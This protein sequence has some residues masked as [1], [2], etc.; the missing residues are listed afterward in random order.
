M[1]KDWKQQEG[2]LRRK[3][4]AAIEPLKKEL[5][6]YKLTEE[7]DS[8]IQA[9]IQESTDKLVSTPTALLDERK[10]VETYGDGK[11]TLRPG[12]NLTEEIIQ[13][14][15]GGEADRTKLRLTVR[16]A[17]QKLKSELFT[18]VSN[19][20]SPIDVIRA[21][22]LGA[23]IDLAAKK[24]GLDKIE[25]QRIRELVVRLSYPPEG[26][27]TAKMELIAEETMVANN[28]PSGKRVEI[29]QANAIYN[30]VHAGKI[31]RTVTEINRISGVLGGSEKLGQLGT[32]AKF[33]K[34]HPTMMR[35]LE[36]IQGL[37]KFQDS[38]AGFIN[39]PVGF[40]LKTEAFKN[41]SVQ[42]ATRLGGQA[43][44]N[45]VAQAGEFT[46]GGA[47]RNFIG[48]LFVKTA[49][50]AAAN[51]AADAV[52][53]GAEASN[54]LGWALAL[55]QVGLSLIKPFLEKIGK[56]LENNLSIGSAK[57][58][59]AM[60]DTFGNIFGTIGYYA[61]EALT[62][63]LGITLGGTAAGFGIIAAVT[64]G[65]LFFFHSSNQR[66]TQLFVAPKGMGADAGCVETDSSGKGTPGT[67]SMN[68]DGTVYTYVDGNGNTWQCSSIPNNTVGGGTPIPGS[69]GLPGETFPGAECDVSSAVVP[70]KQCDGTWANTSLI[71]ARCSGGGPGTICS[72]G[73]GP[74]S[75]SMLLR[76]INGGLTPPGTI[77]EAG[78]PYSSMG[79]DGSSLQQAITSLSNHGL[80]AQMAAGSSCSPKDIAGWICQHKVVLVL[81]NF[82][83][84][85]SDLTSFG[86][87]FILAVAVKGGK[88]YS[89]DPYYNTAT[90]FDGTT[91]FGYVHD[92]MG[93]VN[94]GRKVEKYVKK[95]KNINR[96]SNRG[97]IFIS[98][99]FSNKN[100]WKSQNRGGNTNTNKS[101]G[102]NKRGGKFS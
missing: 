26:P 100:R 58:K 82:Y 59:Q 74:T 80:N 23:G 44:G 12:K 87:H 33:L 47:I 49:A 8:E 86:G 61:G 18:D 51:L 71:G 35:S 95:H 91:A 1:R 57:T 7:Q 94:C 39:N 27:S 73:C 68:S 78:S 30:L 75:V 92:I 52:I 90:P 54:P 40:L 98:D 2:S 89:A 37:V 21:E 42:L 4:K 65:F 99:K 84:N 62:G 34:D 53:A 85:S 50:P 63:I 48:G 64:L 22:N 77:F 6:D 43:M 20:Q 5:K 96:S 31:D 88:I 60:K 10:I 102:T 66:M 76:H 15:N 72:S 24:A 79:C 101:D 70:E 69:P 14:I 9:L 56:G 36:T 13:V 3:L 11:T 19:K 41:F 45:M 93:C 81:A 67:N 32:V 46:L 28:L 38:I 29:E 25:A 16:E 97:S 17:E 83:H 55:I